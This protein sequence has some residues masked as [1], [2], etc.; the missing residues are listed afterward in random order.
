MTML[1]KILLI[2]L[3]LLLIGLVAFVVIV[4]GG[5]KF[6]QGALYN[7]RP[8]YREC[9][10]EGQNYQSEQAEDCENFTTKL[11]SGVFPDGEYTIF[12]KYSDK[13]LP[14]N[15]IPVKIS[16]KGKTLAC[17]FLE[18]NY[19]PEV[20]VF[21]VTD[22]LSIQ[23]LK[24]DQETPVNSQGT[25]AQIN[26]SKNDQTYFYDT[27]IC[28]RAFQSILYD[29]EKNILGTALM[30]HN[31][32][33]NSRPLVNEVLISSSP[34][35]TDKNGQAQKTFSAG[36]IF[37][38][39]NFAPDIL[40]KFTIPCS[41]EKPSVY[42]PSLETKKDVEIPFQGL[43]KNY[44]DTCGSRLYL[45]L[46]NTNRIDDIQIFD[47]LDLDSTEDPPSYLMKLSQIARINAKDTTFP[48][49]FKISLHLRD[50]SD[51]SEVITLGNGLLTIPS[52][53]PAKS[54]SQTEDDN[55][56]DESLSSGDI[57]E[58]I[59]DNS[60]SADA[61]RKTPRPKVRRN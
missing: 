36:N 48:I 8:I 57:G 21:P 53:K 56:I 25:V 59:K 30:D 10:I 23:R 14:D 9:R 61:T 15:I 60:S 43:N 19:L 12:A 52:Y 5:G 58:A 33:I 55:P 6:F 34:Y 37:A 27:N 50:R 20:S 26:Y 40:F 39:I 31:G 41:S 17:T 18:N 45:S 3:L 32:F 11:D 28:E 4:G 24:P 7:L 1:K 54:T 42:I 35:Y 47:N 49:S 38:G 29:N 46:Q 16:E 44:L 13:L 2:I 51:S 22:P